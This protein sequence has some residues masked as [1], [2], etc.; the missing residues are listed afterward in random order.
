MPSLKVELSAKNK[1]REIFL[2]EVKFAAIAFS[3]GLTI[4]AA[5]LREIAKNIYDHAQG[6]GYLILNKTGNAVEFK[7]GNRGAPPTG[8]KWEVKKSSLAGNGVNFGVG[9]NLIPQLAEALGI[10]LKIDIPGGY[11]YSGT[12]LIKKP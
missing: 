12:Y 9:I 10:E 6:N 1:T 5:L 2:R 3:G 11:V 7:I 8:H 4:F